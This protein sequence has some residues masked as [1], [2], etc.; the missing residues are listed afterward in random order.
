M[1]GNGIS[2]DTGAIAPSNT[3][4]D[5]Q[6]PDSKLIPRRGIACNAPTNWKYIDRIYYNVPNKGIFTTERL[7]LRSLLLLASNGQCRAARGHNLPGW[8]AP[9][10]HRETV[11]KSD[12]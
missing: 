11:G 1:R 4:S 6:S 12:R 7:V 3:Y 2:S 8:P 9:S 5:P 10:R